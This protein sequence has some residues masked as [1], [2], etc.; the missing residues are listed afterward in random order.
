MNSYQSAKREKE[1]YLRWK[2]FTSYEK[3]LRE[4]KTWEQ[5]TDRQ[6][7]SKSK[8]WPLCISKSAIGAV[9]KITGQQNVNVKSQNR[10]MNLG[11]KILKHNLQRNLWALELTFLQQK[12]CLAHNS[13]AATN[14][15]Y[16]LVSHTG[17]NVCEASHTTVNFRP[18]EEL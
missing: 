4:E 5:I 17:L 12:H 16:K 14:S 7:V 2:M 3:P 11:F 18:E 10:K 13:H 1:T 15:I 6:E 9:S 8:H